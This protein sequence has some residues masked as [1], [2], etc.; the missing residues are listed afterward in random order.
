[1]LS[2]LCSVV[3]SAMGAPLP[4]ETFFKKAKYGG[5]T[6]SP[7]GRYLAVITPINGRLNV[8]VMDLDT[9][10]VNAVSS[11]S[12]G[13]VY[14]VVWQTDERMVVIVADLHRATGESPRVFGI[15]AVNRD[16][17]QPRAFAE[18]IAQGR[19][20][21]EARGIGRSFERPWALRFQRV[22]RGSDDVLV[23]ARERSVDSV[24]VYR[25]DTITGKKTLLSFDSPG[26]ASHWVVDFK[27]VPRAV[28]TDDLDHDKSAWYVRKTENDPWR[29]VEEAGL[30]RLKST[31][32]FFSQDG[33]ILYVKSRRN[34]DLAAIYEY[35]VG[36]AKWNG[37]AIAH[38]ERDIEAT[39]VIDTDQRELL[40]LRYVDD[41]PSVVWFDARWARMQ[42]SV[43]AALPD[44]VNVLQQSRGSRWIV[45]AYSDRN[46]GEVYLL[47]GKTMKMEKL[48]SYV[49][50]ID[51]AEIAPTQW[52][53]YKA[54][55]GLVI[56]ALL[57]VP[58]DAAGKPVPLIV[59]IHGGPNVYATTWGYHI[60]FPEVNFFASRGYAV[61]QPQ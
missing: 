57:T 54:R 49:P 29:K 5:A 32:L 1:L 7:S 4:V 30:G 24:D 14:N 58:R 31:P 33:K 11:F 9:R 47:D 42:K 23:T 38:P 39:F 60:Y 36:A 8:A 46:P 45:V 19:I 53:R 13:D 3:A 6:L 18:P 22:I 41:K 27:N 51:P 34:R 12:S 56:P 20:A 26:K 50:W 48:F 21:N 44:T 28:V 15:W 55:D 52:V 17:S 37:P 2:L 35:D 43:D 10:A 16:G 40:G 25:Y 59:D 61:L